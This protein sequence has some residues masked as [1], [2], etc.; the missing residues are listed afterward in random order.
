[1][2]FWPSTHP[3]FA[4]LSVNLKIK[5]SQPYMTKTHRGENPW[6]LGCLLSEEP[7]TKSK[8]KVKHH[9]NNP[10]NFVERGKE[11]E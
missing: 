6:V 4:K 10:Y 7:K 2:Y 5:S 8:L 9:N 1:M 11:Q 3:N